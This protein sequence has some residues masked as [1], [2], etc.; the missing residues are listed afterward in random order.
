MTPPGP[1]PDVFA[2]ALAGLPEQGAASPFHRCFGCGPAHPD[3][4]HVRSFRTEDGVCDLFPGAPSAKPRAV[5]VEGGRV[6]VAR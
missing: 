1:I 5:R 6:L 3:G 4:L 2:A